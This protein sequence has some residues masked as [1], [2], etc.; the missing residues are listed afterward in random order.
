MFGTEELTF[1]RLIL[2]PRDPPFES[3]DLPSPL[4][5]VGL[6]SGIAHCFSFS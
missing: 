6:T 4:V 5:R 1:F 3:T 2:S